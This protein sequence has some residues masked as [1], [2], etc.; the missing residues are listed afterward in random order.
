MFLPTAYPIYK[1]HKLYW[2]DADNLVGN[3]ANTAYD[4]TPYLYESNVYN[5]LSSYDD[6][7]PV[8][9]AYALY[10]TQEQKG[11]QG[12]FFKN[13]DITG[14]ALVNYAIVNVIK[15][16]TSYEITSGNYTGLCFRV[17]YTPVYSARIGHSKQYIGRDKFFI[18]YLFRQ[19]D[20]V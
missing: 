6:V 3:G 17:E 4:L 5:S 20:R 15:A 10:Y 16:A 8:S 12:F 19:R 1:V 9:K 14:G 13:P 2:I 18:L 11:I 7:Y